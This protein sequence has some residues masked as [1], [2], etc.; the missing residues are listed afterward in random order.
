MEN[1]AKPLWGI[2]KET[3]VKKFLL[4]MLTIATLSGA[5]L[6]IHSG[7]AAARGC[8]GVPGNTYDCE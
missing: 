2:L 4:A 1:L 8:G 5:V 6:V 7:P 3:I